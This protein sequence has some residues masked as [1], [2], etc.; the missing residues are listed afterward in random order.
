M[1]NIKANEIQFENSLQDWMRE[2][3]DG[4]I[5]CQINVILKEKRNKIE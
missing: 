1:L 3:K 4:N 2:N 5:K